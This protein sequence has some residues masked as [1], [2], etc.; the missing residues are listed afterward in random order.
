MAAEDRTQDTLFFARRLSEAGFHLRSVIVNR[1]HPRPEGVGESAGEP[2][3]LEHLARAVAEREAGALASAVDLLAGAATVE[4]LPLL[5][6]EPVD[7]AE[8]RRLAARRTRL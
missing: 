1:L 4:T 5:A 7:V 8:L 2:T 6:R 3:A